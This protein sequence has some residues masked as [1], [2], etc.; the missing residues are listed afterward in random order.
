ME[1]LVRFQVAITAQQ[2]DELE[3]LMAAGGLSTNRDLFNNAITLLKWAA[4]EKARGSAIVSV[5]ELETSVK[6]LE[7]PFLEAVAAS[8][9][10]KK[11]RPSRAHVPLTAVAVNRRRR[12]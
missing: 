9:T 8:M 5:N 4:R 12:D 11:Q 7:L 10:T 1:K 6:E 3:Q 2:Y